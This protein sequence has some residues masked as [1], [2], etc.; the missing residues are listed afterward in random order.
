MM[1][2]TGKQEKYAIAPLKESMMILK[3]QQFVTCMR[4]MQKLGYAV[5]MDYKE[6]TDDPVGTLNPKTYNI[7]KPENEPT[8]AQAVFYKTPL[9]TSR[10]LPV[11]DTIFEGV[12]INQA[13]MNFLPQKPTVARPGTEFRSIMKYGLAGHK[14]YQKQ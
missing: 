6:T 14:A 3:R 12:M 4:T 1:C 10:Q 5:L 13:N 11:M 9:A 7:F 8:P 2:V